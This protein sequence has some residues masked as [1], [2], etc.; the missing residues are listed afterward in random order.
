MSKKVFILIKLMAILFVSCSAFAVSPEWTGQGQ[1]RLLVKVDPVILTNGRSSDDLIGR[2]EIDFDALMTEFSGSGY[3]DLSTIQV[4][5]FDPDTGAALTYPAFD[6]AVSPYD[7]PCRFED[8]IAPDDY[9]QRS[10]YASNYGDGLAPRSTFK[11][12][13]RLFN[14]A[15][16]NHTGKIIWTH[17][18][19]DSLSSYYAI[20]W[21]TKVSKSQIGLSPAP[22]IGDADV[23]RLEDNLPLAPYSH[24]RSTVGDLNGDGL[25]DIVMAEQKGNVLFYPNMGSI[26]NPRFL[27]C[28]PLIDEYGPID[29]GWYGAA[30]LYDWNDDGLID[31]LVG[32]SHNVIL[33]WENVGTTTD[34]Q[35]DYQG[36]LQADGARL[37]TPETP[38]AESSVFVVDYFTM[39]FVCDWNQDGLPDILTGSYITGQISY[40]RC[41]GRTGGVP[42]LTF[43]GLIQ[44]DGDVLDTVWAA[45]PL[46]YDF[47]NDGKMDLISG[48]WNFG[49]G[50]TNIEMLHYYKNTGTASVPVL[51]R[52]SFPMQGSF[53]SGTLAHAVT[54]DWNN[55]SLMD[56]LVST[57]GGHMYCFL[58]VGTQNAPLW[59]VHSNELETKWGIWPN[60]LNA[61]SVMDWDNDGYKE[62]LHGSRIYRLTG[63]PHSPTN[64]TVG[65]CTVDGSAIY[66]E[67]PGYGDHYNWNVLADWD[68]DGLT[69]IL[70]GIHQ[71][72]IYFHKNSGDPS[73]LVF[74]TGIKLKLLTGEEVKVGPP[75][76]KDPD[77]VPDFVAL[78][79]SRAKPFMDD[80]DGDGINDLLI[81]EH[82]KIWVFRN[83]VAGATDK[84]QAGVVVGTG[85][86]RF[87]VTTIDWNQDNKNDIIVGVPVSSPG[88]IYENQSTPG[89]PVYAAGITPLDLPYLFYNT[90]LHN[91]DWNDDGDDDFLAEGEYFGF[92]IEGSFMEHDYVYGTRVVT[93]N[94]VL[95]ETGG[96][97]DVTEEGETSDTYTVALDEDPLEPVTVTI[98]TDGQIT[99]DPNQLDFDSSNWQNPQLVNVHAVDD[100]VYESYLP[101]THPS[102]ITHTIPGDN[103]V[104]AGYLTA[105]ISDNDRICGDPG[106]VYRPQDIN[107]D[108]YVDLKDLASL[109]AIWMRCYDPT[110]PQNCD[111]LLQ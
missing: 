4:H 74:D 3:V 34:Y 6:N 47:N 81:A 56:L 64:T 51:Q 67:G 44:A 55:D 12:A 29:A 50:G 95:V 62:I 87:P 41:S 23:L 71:G 76:Y 83:T 92:W 24:V 33:W 57:Y 104:I 19:D 10:G 52:Q 32:T 20:Y 69:D 2:Y 37:E 99:V 97:T 89:S 35:F 36:C 72:N 78:Q 63:S 105:N 65:V 86:S 93:T 101:D 16:E 106:T 25:F 77:D 11:R 1:Y 13:G 14:R 107:R 84:L 60:I 30:V 111:L 28:Q 85:V 42:D 26:G 17:T 96:S 98:T 38:C 54:V 59:D 31:L 88:T 91:S 15:M 49:G 61:W 79:G 53:P 75:V 73:N 66:H 108:C 90:V 7:R 46:G 102:V 82:D 8:N 100:D 94:V 43:E 58:N 21:D 68:G 39:P 45:H 5:R 110:D 70:C 22:F 18:Q 80:A 109:A 48:S 103:V 9:P 27:G 40:Y